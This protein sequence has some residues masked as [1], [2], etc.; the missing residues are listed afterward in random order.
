MSDPSTARVVELAK[1]SFEGVTI[2][3]IVRVEDARVWVDFRGNPA[4]PVAATCTVSVSR[5]DIDR[6]IATRQ[7]AAL[8]FEQADP[9]RPVLLGLVQDLLEGELA[10]STAPQVIVD[11]DRVEVDATRELVLRCGKAS[12]TLRANGRVTIRGVHVETRAAGTNRIK[13]GNVQI[14]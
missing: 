4:G 6:A 8:V 1:P 10:E 12:I 5:A 9:K 11:G 7:G 14:N 13:G 2:G 3:W